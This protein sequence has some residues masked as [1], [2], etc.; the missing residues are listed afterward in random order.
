[1]KSFNDFSVKYN[2]QGDMDAE[3][4][5]E[6]H[7][8]FNNQIYNPKTKTSGGVSYLV[9]SDEY[10]VSISEMDCVG[11]AINTYVGFAL[12]HIFDGIEAHVET[13]KINDTIYKK[14]VVDGKIDSVWNN[15]QFGIS[16]FVM[17]PTSGSISFGYLGAD[18]FTGTGIAE[19]SR[20]YYH[21]E[22]QPDA[23]S[24]NS[25]SVFSLQNSYDIGSGVPDIRYLFNYKYLIAVDKTYTYVDNSGSI[26]DRCNVMLRINYE[27][28]NS[29]LLSWDVINNQLSNNWA[30]NAQ[31]KQYLS[32]S[33]EKIAAINNAILQG[34]ILN[35]ETS[36]V[37]KSSQTQPRFI[38][39]F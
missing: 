20:Y 6:G 18:L 17:R 21:Y 4:I 10:S 1:M 8:S 11:N 32:M 5:P 39:P 12:H 23:T 36:K 34:K 30:N 37:L 14:F 16:L 13:T 3:T 15:T 31:L 19:S 35:F 33:D 29:V 28:I 25:P 9:P 2:P 27:Y 24:G 26:D 7:Q 38:I 22:F